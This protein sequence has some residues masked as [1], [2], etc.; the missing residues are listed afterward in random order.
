[1]DL[2]YDLVIVGGGPAALS[3]AIYA[4]R[5]ELKTIVLERQRI[6]GQ[7]VGTYDVDNYPGFP[8]GITGPELIDRM[9][10]QARRF[11]AEFAT[12]EVERVELDGDTKVAV[13]KE[14]TYRSPALIFAVGA[15]PRKL[16]IAGENELRGRGVSYCATCDGPFFKEKKVVVVGGG[17]AA[18]KEGLFI[19][20]FA[21]EVLFIHRREEFRAEKIYQTEAEN[22]PKISF[23]LNTVVTR[24]NGDKKVESVDVKNAQTGEEKTIA[25][26]GVFI[27]IGHV[28]NTNF[29]CNLFPVDCGGHLETDLRMM[30]SIPGVFA[31]G[32][33]REHSYR[34]IATAVGE[35]ATA[36]IEA[37]GLVDRIKAQ[38]K[39]K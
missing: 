11:G 32:D 31:I 19:T 17:D 7:L 15:G 12:E 36:S 4:G 29:L 22:N 5:A 6:G 10:K 8:E 9:E 33:A 24:I 35:G 13:G 28:P 2:D 1:M 34:Q 27:F 23:E 16:E 39:T 38:G 25:C 3:A 26:D 37:E 21:R 14:N 30:T 18:F 20:K